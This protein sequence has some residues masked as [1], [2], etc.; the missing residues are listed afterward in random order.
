MIRLKIFF[1][2]LFMSITAFAKEYNYE[3]AQGEIIGT[4]IQKMYYGPPG[5]GEDPKN[6]PKVYPYLLKTDTPNDFI[7]DGK[8][9]T[10][11]TEKGI[12]ELQI[13]LENE[14]IDL[15]NFLHKK[16]KIKGTF[17]HAVSGGHHTKVLIN[18]Q[19]VIGD[20]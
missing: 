2:I 8:D 20:K 11:S 16:V 7:S 1:F 15:K 10:N 18:A 9:P 5:Y 13:F 3:P 4:I 6:D 14:K 17:S 12:A 19:D